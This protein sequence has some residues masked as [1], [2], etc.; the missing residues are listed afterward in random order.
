M[1]L[2]WYKLEKNKITEKEIEVKET[3]KLYKA[4]DKR[5]FPYDC[6]MTIEKT[7]EGEILTSWEGTFVFFSEKNIEKARDLFIES[8]KKAIES[9]N[10]QIRRLEQ[11]IEE[12]ERQIDKLEDMEV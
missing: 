5:Y 4:F 12:L 10:N 7:R 1:K 8:Q 2:Y 3:I 9:K 11:E 6:R